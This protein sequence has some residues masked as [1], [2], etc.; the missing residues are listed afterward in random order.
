VWP[1]EEQ[2]HARASHA[3]IERGCVRP[4]HHSTD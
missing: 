1:P 4:D 2:R 3:P